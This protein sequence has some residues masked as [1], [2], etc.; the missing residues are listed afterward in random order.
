[1][2][3]KSL[4]DILE[5]RAR[6]QRDRV[7]YTFL[8]DGEIQCGTLTFGSLYEKAVTLARALNRVC[9]P[10]DRALLLYPAGLD[11]IVAFL[12]C[13]FAGV[14]AVPVY[15]PRSRIAN[16]R[17]FAVRQDAEPSILLTTSEIL[18]KGFPTLLAGLRPLATDIHESSGSHRLDRSPRGDEVAFLQYTSGSTA[19]PR[20]VIVSHENIIQ[21]SAC[22]KEA[23]QY[24]AD[25]VAVTWLP[26]FHDMGLIEALLQPIV[27]GFPTYIFP[28]AAFL[29]RPL[30]WLSVISR[31]RATH[32][33]AP[34]FAYDLCTQSLSRQT[35]TLDLSCWR[36][37]YNA[38]EPIRQETLERFSGAF[39]PYGFRRNAFYPAY[40][41]AE[42]TLQVAGG[43]KGEGPRYV[44]PPHAASVAAQDELG[45][46]KYQPRT[47]VSCGRPLADTHIAIVDPK[48]HEQ[49]EE[50]Q[51]GEIWVAGTS[52]SRGYW[53]REKE[54]GETFGARIRR[55]GKGPFLRTGDLGLMIE[56]ELFVTGRLKE[57]I[58]VQG[59]KHFS[60][61]LEDTA[62]RSYEFLMP[63]KYAAFGI[64]N[65]R[66]DEV[67][68][69]IE[70]SR[71]DVRAFRNKEIPTRFEN[72]VSAIVGG[73]CE[74]HD[75]RPASVVF[76][77]PCSIPHTSSGKIQRFRCQDLYLHGGF[78][79]LYESKSRLKQPRSLSMVGSF[80]EA[81][82]HALLQDEA[83]A[84]CEDRPY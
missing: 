73:V 1:M 14:I 32:S 12:G 27:H 30:R 83:R 4:L 43:V 7:V 31:Y 41:L 18:N 52:V 36:L 74:E 29:Q 16:R 76:L 22:L 49:C 50:R 34:N 81:N 20:G 58:I 24:G 46:A 45:G 78:N 62:R 72:V 66:F 35:L 11:F 84:H 48:T 64:S 80:Y 59:R 65:G 67:I 23:A 71:Q 5:D 13:L 38:A 82:N 33:G 63:A 57:T 39:G 9:A 53:H 15:P 21:N 37:A 6:C 28:P 3:M 60:Q 56:G 77:K 26:H 42:A 10:G 47:L 2:A 79:V 25:T 54:T 68:L 19:S 75:V 40:G 51:V 17:I 69:L 8:P 70:L 61:D 44:V 55:T